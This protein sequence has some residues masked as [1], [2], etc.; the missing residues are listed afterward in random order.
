M[1]FKTIFLVVFVF[2]SL[3]SCSNNNLKH[4][5]KVSLGKIVDGNTIGV[6]IDNKLKNVKLSSIE[7]PSVRGSYPFSIEAKKFIESR[8][9]DDEYVY[10]EKIEEN[11]KNARI[12]AF[13]WH[14]DNGELKLLN[15][16]LVSEGFA[17][18]L[19]LEGEKYFEMLSLSQENAKS[20]KK[21]IWSIDGYVTEKG[22]KSQS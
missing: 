5:E 15:D 20:A 12:V 6:Y 16:D 18:F 8:L 1:K 10:L 13:V 21:N 14:Y 11:N 17:R 22:F 7:A 3:V 4:M 19:G 9:S 2:L